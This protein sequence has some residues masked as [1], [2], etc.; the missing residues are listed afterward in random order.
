MDEE[1][2]LSVAI[3]QAPE[4]IPVTAKSSLIISALP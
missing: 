2:A 3:P 4:P 1:L